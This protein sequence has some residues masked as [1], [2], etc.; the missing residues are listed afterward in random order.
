M[1]RG[2]LYLM[3]ANGAFFVAG[4]IIH[5]GLGR[6]L[7]PVD[8]GT[9]GVI[10]S[11]MTIVNTFLTSGFPQSASKHIAEDDTK[12]GSIIR[13][14]NRIQLALCA[15]LF[16]LYFGLAS[17]IANLLNDP[18]LTPYIRI[19]ASVVPTYALYAIYSAGYLNGLR[20]FGKQAMS[21]IGDSMAKVGTVFVLVLLGFGVK[22]AIV[23]YPLAALIGF[24]LAWKLLGPVERS[25][26]NYDWK[27][28]AG[29][30]I[31]ATLFAVILFL[32]MSIDLFVVKAFGKGEAEVGYYTSATTISRAP[33][34]L[35]TGLGLALLPS[36][37]KSTSMYN[38]EL[39]RNYIRQSVRYML[40]LLIPGTLLI[41]ATSVDLI[42]L[43]YS[44][45]YVE[46]A[47]PLSVL[48]VG[49]GFLSVF[50]VLANII[51][52]S[53][54]PRVTLW[55][56]LPL[57]VIDIGLNVFLVPKYSLVG[58]AWA[59]TITGS[60]GMCATAV[61]VLWRF[62]AL[63][64]AKSLGRICL[65]SSVIYVIALQVSV[66][67]QWLLPFYIGIFAIYGG[68]LLLTKELGKGDW[69]TFKRIIPTHSFAGGGDFTP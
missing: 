24:L 14:A 31:T 13:D 18:K 4:Y 58:A 35:F 25:S 55:M 26:V 51:M 45:R 60:L 47:G 56:A 40:I 59:T 61:Y 20:Q 69:E 49:L 46:A 6:F 23:G 30:G 38:A 52:G 2:T 32:L 68:I 19:S 44:S 33:Y 8:Y 16:A 12:I 63:V 10:L 67:P 17:V 36:I 11:L 34:A 64:S 50:F 48:V 29:F 37:S 28:L 54:K 27:K 62:K 7:G 21:R 42:T 5:F 3:I 43:V 66:S 65:A 53:G 41:S 15:V 9:F 1:G 22:G 39:T 57:V